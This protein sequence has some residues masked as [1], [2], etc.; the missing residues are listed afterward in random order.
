MDRL[1]FDREDGPG[2][3]GAYGAPPEGQKAYFRI[4][5]AQHVSPSSTA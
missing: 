1:E 3:P 4:A 5:M 2:L